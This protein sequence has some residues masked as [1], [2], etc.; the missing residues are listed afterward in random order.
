MKKVS[1]NYI[2]YVKKY[3]EENGKKKPTR[4]SKM[5]KWH[6]ARKSP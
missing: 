5:L 4:G 1:L 3:F 2:I 6:K